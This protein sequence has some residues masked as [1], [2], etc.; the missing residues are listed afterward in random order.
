MRVL[1][2]LLCGICLLFGQTP[3]DDYGICSTIKIQYEKSQHAEYNADKDS[4]KLFDD[5]EKL[6]TNIIDLDTKVPKMSGNNPLYPQAQLVYLGGDVIGETFYLVEQNGLQNIF[7]M[8]IFP[9]L[10]R[11]IL[12][13][14]YINKKELLDNTNGFYATMMFGSYSCVK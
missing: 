2:L 3:A 14:Q 12:H 13:K 6:V 5:K 10:K 7:L 4:L 1:V 9:K 8:T 11:V